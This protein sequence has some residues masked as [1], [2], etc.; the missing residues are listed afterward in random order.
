[1]DATSI[2]LAHSFPCFDSTGQNFQCPAQRAPNT[3]GMYWNQMEP[4]IIHGH[5]IDLNPIDLSSIQ[6]NEMSRV[7]KKPTTV[8]FHAS[9]FQNPEAPDRQFQNL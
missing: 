1:M 5:L 9:Q 8:H 3:N 4:K 6:S 7:N 2:M